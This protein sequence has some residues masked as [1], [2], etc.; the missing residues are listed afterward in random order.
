[1]FSRRSAFRWIPGGGYNALLMSIAVL[2]SLASAVAYGLSDFA[3]GVLSRR[4]SAWAVATMSQGTAAVLTAALLTTNIGHSTAA[5]LLWGILAGIGSRAGNVFIYRGLAAGRMTVVAPVSVIAAAVLPVLVGIVAGERPG[6]LPTIGV[7]TG[8]PAIWLVSGGRG[9]R[10]V[11]QVDMVNGLIAGAGFGLQFSALGQIPR[12]A[13]LMPLA[14]SQAA[15]VLAIITGAV[16]LSAQWAPRDRFSR[17]GAI[18]GLLAGVATIC[19]QLAVQ[20][21]LL[22]VAAVLT[23]LYPAVTVLLAALLLRERVQRAQGVGLTLA[24]AAVSLI[25]SG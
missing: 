15:S 6:R 8:L 7:L 3:G 21:G 13:G 14:V 9:L 12:E 11:A 10:H 2:L 25:A 22:T 24:A 20:A 19:F 23:S 18:A 17:L 16:M 5:N 1:M 4:A